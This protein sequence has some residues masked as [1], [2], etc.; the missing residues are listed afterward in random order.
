MNLLKSVEN[1]KAYSIKKPARIFERVFLWLVC[2]L[3]LHLLNYGLAYSGKG[4]ATIVEQ[5]LHGH[6]FG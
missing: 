5:I 4:E 2:Q 3:F 1:K 6:H